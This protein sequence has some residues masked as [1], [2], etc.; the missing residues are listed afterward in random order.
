MLLEL[1]F[2]ISVVCVLFIDYID[3]IDYRLLCF[4]LPALWCLQ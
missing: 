1:F 3:Y 4:A 2:A